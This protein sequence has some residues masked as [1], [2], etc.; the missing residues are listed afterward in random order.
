MRTVIITGA[1]SGI[2]RAVASRFTADGDIV[3]LT[4]RRIEALRNAAEKIAAEQPGQ[5]RAVAFNAS[6]PTDVQAAVNRLPERVDVLVNNAGGNTDFDRPAPE[7]LPELAAAWWANLSSNL[8]SAVLV[9]TAVQDRLAAG[10]AVVSIGSIAADKR[11]GSY[12]AAKAALASWTVDLAR[13][14]GPRDI[15]VNT[16]VPGLRSRHRVL[17][18]PIHRPAAPGAGRLLACWAAQPTR[19]HRRPDP[20][21]RLPRRTSNHRPSLIGQR[22]GAN[23]AMSP[24]GTAYPRWRDL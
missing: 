5:T 10:G 19:R 24:A 8:I 4:G 13:Q 3:V 1:S 16:V 14:L 11:A 12:G 9:T 7:G 18:R 20:L 23:N 2:G 22:R 6:D 15:T 21:P 17:P